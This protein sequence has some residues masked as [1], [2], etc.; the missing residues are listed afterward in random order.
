M[1]W[2]AGRERQCPRDHVERVLG[3]GAGDEAAVAAPA[4]VLA[5]H[6]GALPVHLVT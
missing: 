6:Y 4:A 3:P 5:S 2:S 1:V